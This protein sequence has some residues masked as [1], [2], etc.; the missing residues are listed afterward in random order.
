MPFSTGQGKSQKP[1]PRGGQKKRLPFHISLGGSS[2]SQTRSEL[3]ED[4][5]VDIF[6]PA[7]VKA[8]QHAEAITTTAEQLEGAVALPRPESAIQP[9]FFPCRSISD[10]R[11]EA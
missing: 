2:A 1:R 10:L 5:L 11:R 3:L 4:L 8:I 6:A 9:G 7:L